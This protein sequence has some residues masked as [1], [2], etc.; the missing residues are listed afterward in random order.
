MV[1]VSDFTNIFF[2]A[3]LTGH[4]LNLDCRVY[5]HF[6]FKQT[7][8]TKWAWNLLVLQSQN[9]VWLFATPWTAA[10]QAPLS[11]TVS[12]S[13]HKFMLAIQP[14]H[15]PSPS[16]PPAFNLSQHQGLFQWVGSSHQ[17]AKV[18]ELQLQHQPFQW[19]V[20]VDPFRIDWFVFLAVQGTVKSLLQPHSSKAPILQCLAFLMV[21]L[22]HLCMTT[23]KT[24]AVTI[25]SFVGK[26][27][28]LLFNMLSKFVIAFLS[29][30][31]HLLILSLGQKMVKI[32]APCG[33]TLWLFDKTLN[34][35]HY[36]MS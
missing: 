28:S 3:W 17:V 6:C 27:M 9:H 1:L 30:S 24:I 29:R 2:F 13:L 32:M 16:S 33:C 7:L 25:W 19:I 31:Q 18:L 4:E 35:I 26:V 5:H 21:Q 22:S 11:S 10:H 8:C 36:K 34:Y 15:P 23:G 20:R 12:Q 14:S